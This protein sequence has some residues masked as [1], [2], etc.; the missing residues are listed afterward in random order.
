MN[1]Y[2]LTLIAIIIFN[3]G[4]GQTLN[5]KNL[6]SSE[7]KQLIN[8]NKGTLLDV[9]TS[10]EF[11]NGHI[12]KSGQLNY[13]AI[14]FKQKLL[15][16][17]KVESI[18]I[19]CNTG[20]RS[21]KA[22]EILIKNGYS[23]VYNLE[24]GIMEWELKD[25]PIIIDANARPDTKD[26]MGA[27]E[28]YALIKSEELIFIDF[29]AP[30]CGPCRKMMPNI[31]LIKKEYQNSI[32]VIKINTDASKRLIKELQVASVPYLVMYKNGKKVYEHNGLLEK[33]KLVK[34]LNLY[35]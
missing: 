19:Y 34:T 3:L 35:L 31:D 12:A 32:K 5:V 22:A 20:Y 21:R 11:S 27:D 1:R 15:L 10:T 16:L 25:L 4:Y 18:Y 13:Y 28:F 29:Y 9:R 30:W 8:K 14:D 26:A 6:N 17:P 24:H 7:F 23:K 2:I 33:E